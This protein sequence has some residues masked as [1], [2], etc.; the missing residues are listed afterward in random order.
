MDND[1]KQDHKIINTL[2][3][4]ISTLAKS[5]NRFSLAF[6]M[7]RKAYEQTEESRRKDAYIIAIITIVGIAITIAASSYWSHVQES[8]IQAYKQASE[9][10]DR[11]NL[12]LNKKDLVMHA[13]SKLRSVRDAGQKKCVN[14][15]YS[16]SNTQVFN[17]Q[18]Y[19][20][21]FGISDAYFVAK[22]ILDKQST[23]A[24]LKLIASVDLDKVNICDPKSIKDEG[25]KA[26][27]IVIN[28]SILDQ[29]EQLMVKKQ[30]YIDEA[31]KE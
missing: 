13:I 29:I 11:I 24:L 10:N 6:D 26:Q 5:F 3:S 28:N 1:H 30:K 12:I 9:A 8:R 23:N 2:E 14:G 25:I 4:V 17:E 21:G 22:G 31:E 18:L 7:V 16:G 20:A 27:Q 15:V 19:N